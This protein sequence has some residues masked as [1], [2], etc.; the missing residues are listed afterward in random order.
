VFIIRVS[1]LATAVFNGEWLDPDHTCGRLRVVVPANTFYADRK[2]VSTE[3]ES[4]F[5]DLVS[6]G[7]YNSERLATSVKGD[8]ISFMGILKS[9]LTQH[10]HDK[11]VYVTD[12]LVQPRVPVESNRGGAADRIPSDLPPM[13]DMTEFESKIP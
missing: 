8:L 11:Y 13:P 1:G 7:R 4:L 3:T 12:C 6:T 5:I 9:A 2:P 10:G